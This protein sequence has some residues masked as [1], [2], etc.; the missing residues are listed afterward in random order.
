MNAGTATSQRLRYVTV[1][2]I[3]TAGR[4]PAAMEACSHVPSHIRFTTVSAT[5]ASTANAIARV[6]LGAGG[7]WHLH[8]GNH[9]GV[10]ADSRYSC[11]AA[12]AAARTIRIGA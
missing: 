11:G 9:A 12:D 2:P 5:N 4:N 3:A 6:V 1:A 8:G 10:V 7:A